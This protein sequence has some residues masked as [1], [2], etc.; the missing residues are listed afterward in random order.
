MVFSPRKKSEEE[1]SPILF[2][3]R[4]DPNKKRPNP[5]GPDLKQRD[6]AQTDLPG[7]KKRKENNNFIRKWA[8]LKEKIIKC[9]SAK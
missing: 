9:N 8:F 4:P 1:E 5:N 2:N 6:Q 3:S 7:K